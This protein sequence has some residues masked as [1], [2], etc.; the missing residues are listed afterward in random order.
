MDTN[1]GKTN[2]TPSDLVELTP[3]LKLFGNKTTI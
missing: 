3:E 1:T 2:G